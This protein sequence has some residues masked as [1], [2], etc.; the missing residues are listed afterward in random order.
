[1]WSDTMSRFI[2]R[3]MIRPS[4]S[5]L[6]AVWA[7]GTADFRDQSVSREGLVW[8]TTTGRYDD[9]IGAGFADRFRA[10]FGRS[11]FGTSASIQYDSVNLLGQ[12]WRSTGNPWSYRSTNAELHRLV[13]RGINGSYF[14]G[15]T[16][17]R[18]MAFGIESKDASLSIAHLTYQVQDGADRIIAPSAYASTSYRRQPWLEQSHA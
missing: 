16:N 15:E 7:P 5:L 12:A 17:H 11:T 13:H 3:F 8:A 4:P 2:N 1:M 18:P 14:F 9:A 10:R 6:Y